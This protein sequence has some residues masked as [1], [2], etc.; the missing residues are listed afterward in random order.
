[1]TLLIC[2]VVGLVVLAGLGVVCWS[3]HHTHNAI[4]TRNRN[5]EERVEANLRRGTKL[6]QPFD[7]WTTH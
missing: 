7:I 3:I 4:Q 5:L 6:F 2:I 1:M